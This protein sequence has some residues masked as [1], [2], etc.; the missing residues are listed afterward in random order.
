MSAEQ[1]PKMMHAWRKHKGCFE[2]IWER[3]ATPTPHLT[4]AL[5]KVIAAGVCRSDYNL[6]NNE[7]Q[8]SWYKDQFTL[9]HE[10]CGRIVQ[11]GSSVTKE[12]GFA[13]GDVV[14]MCAVPGCGA[15]DC[16]E[17]S[18]DLPQLCLNGYRSGIGM[19]GFF[20]EYCVV[21]AA[22][23]TDAVTTAYHAIHRRGKITSKDVVFLFGLDGLGF[24][25][26]Q[27]IKAIGAR[28][29]V[30]DVK[31]ENL[32]DAIGLGVSQEDVVPV[33]KNIREWVRENGRDGMISVTADFVGTEQ[34][35]SD[36]QHIVRQAGRLLCV[37]TLNHDNTVHM[38]LAIRK[39]LDIIFSYGGQTKD[40]KEALDLIAQ[41]ILNPTVADGNFEALPKVIENLEAGK[42]Q[43]RVALVLA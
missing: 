20:A 32:D 18:C 25:A 33:G 31:Q 24:N 3:V 7:N 40:I 4:G 26:L 35:F 12:S 42:V 10:G 23:A 27:I 2:P 29:F 34:T 17:C 38:K 22:V 14:A 36:A 21:D 13:I 11:L 41:G 43:G 30:S 8:P 39:R 37:G 1:E 15:P 6:L 9:G 5:V 16:E 19:D 28:V